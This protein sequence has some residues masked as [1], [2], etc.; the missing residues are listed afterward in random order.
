MNHFVT[1]SQT[2]LQDLLFM[3]GAF[4]RAFLVFDGDFPQGNG[5][6]ANH[7]FRIEIS[8]ENMAVMRELAE[9]V[10]KQANSAGG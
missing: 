10:M 4:F 9:G 3:I 6:A 1:G 5:A 2:I 8:A 7:V